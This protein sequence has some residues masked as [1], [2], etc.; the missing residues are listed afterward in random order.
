MRTVSPR[1]AAVQVVRGLHRGD[2]SLTSLLEKWLV[3]VADADRPLVQELCYGT[4]RYYHV[5][6]ALLARLMN[7]PLRNKEDAVLCLLLVGL[8]QLRHMRI[9][10]HAALNETVS[11]AGELGKSWARGLVNGVLR[12]YRREQDTLENALSESARLSFP[13]WL[14]KQLAADWPDDYAEI[15]RQSNRYPPMTLRIDT[16]AVSQAEYLSRLG[17]R[18]LAA[19]GLGWAPS[20]LVLEKAAAVTALPGFAQGLVSVQDAAAQLA[21][22]LLAPAPASRVLD[23]CAAPGGKTLHLLQQVAALQVDAVD[24]D[25]GR[26]S[27]VE[28]NLQRWW[29]NE[30]TPATAR[31]QVRLIPADAAALPEWWDQRPYDAILLDAPCSGT[32][33]IRRHP[34]IKM[35]RRADDIPALVQTTRRL[36]E[37]LWQT[38]KPGGCMLFVTCSILRAENAEQMEWFLSQT[39]DARVV[40]L[41]KDR[42]WLSAE[43]P[44]GEQPSGEKSTR[45]QPSGVWPVG[46]RQS[47]VGWQLLPTAT[48]DGFYYCLL[49]RTQAPS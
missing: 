1:F 48:H 26:L 28:D 49:Q 9:A 15:C 12:N 37:N 6:T 29:N 16:N 44:S 13:D 41:P 46:S 19:G 33:V 32:G 22:P 3:Q 38:L 45:K 8:Y 31:S 40:D 42:E 35:L 11:V 36:L 21:A 27:R 43:Q 20:A 18:D 47:G 24:I 2:G 10:P 4:A 7:K 17:A 5:L 25:A 34:D 14:L 23:A 39:P 30:N